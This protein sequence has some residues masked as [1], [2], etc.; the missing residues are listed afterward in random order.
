MCCW[1]A[2]MLLFVIGDWLSGSWGSYQFNNK[3]CKLFLLV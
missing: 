3:K 1:I 2:R